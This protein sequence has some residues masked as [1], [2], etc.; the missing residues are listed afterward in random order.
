MVGP[1][2]ALVPEPHILKRTD[3]LVTCLYQSNSAN[4]YTSVCGTTA[5]NDAAGN[6][7]K[8]RYGYTYLYD[9]E[10]RLTQIRKTNNCLVVDKISW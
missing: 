2:S 8:D 9:H 10:N 3:R 6:V 4:E 7:S 1:L 5:L